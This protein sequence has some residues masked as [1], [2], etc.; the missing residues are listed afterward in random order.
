MADVLN[1]N[2]IGPF[3]INGNFSAERKENLLWNV[4]I[5]AITEIVRENLIYV[6]FQ[7][8]G[9]APYYGQKVRNYS[10][11]NFLDWNAR[12]PDLATWT[13]PQK[14]NELRQKLIDVAALIPAHF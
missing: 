14:L 9:A 2:L 10:N 6:W 12:S 7:Q 3:F 4:I 1:N 13:K 8:D 5:P 11:E